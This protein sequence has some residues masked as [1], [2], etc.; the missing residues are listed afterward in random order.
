M[1]PFINVLMP[2]YYYLRLCGMVS[3]LTACAVGPHYSPPSAVVPATWGVANKPTS[4]TTSTGWWRHFHDPLLTHLIET[5]SHQNLNAALVQEKVNAAKAEYAVAFAQLFP[6]ANA[7]FLPPN[8]T[9]FDLTQILALTATIDPDFF[10]KNR[11]L[12]EH[13]KAQLEAE[14]AEQQGFQLD[15][16]A[17]I[18]SAYLQLREAQERGRILQQNLHHNQQLFSFIQSR[19]KKGLISYIPIAEQRGLIHIQAAEIEKNNAL[20]HL[21][22]HQIEQLIGANPDAL[23][24]ELEPYKPMPTIKNHIHLGVPA[25]LLCRRPDIIAAERRVAAAHA[26]IR[27]AMA[28]LFPELN[29]G[30]LLAWQTQS[31]GR[32]LFSL[33]DKE[34]SFFGTMAAPL[35]NL[36]LHRMVSLRERE[37][38][39]AV[40]HYQLTVLKALHEVKTQYDYYTH[41]KASTQHLK[42]AVADKKLVL[43]LIKNTYEHKLSDFNTVLRT[44][45]DVNRL[46]LLY[47]HDKTIYQ[48]AQIKLYKTLGE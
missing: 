1:R 10:G 27:I 9:G 29:L 47:L 40:L 26:N 34:S 31:I 38:A 17:S 42:Q 12:R 11:Q 46:A 30:W 43:R 21:R 48:L 32:V 37:K 28:S 4:S 45:E 25:Q 3:I 2:Y 41:Y 8:G 6:K 44:E 16:Q 35:F 39:L 33:Q 24:K 23:A 18:A 15:L 14:Q 5:Q 22:M 19:Y 20:I 13:V 36:N 7:N